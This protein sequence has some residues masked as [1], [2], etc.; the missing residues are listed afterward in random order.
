MVDVAIFDEDKKKNNEDRIGLNGGEKN[1]QHRGRKKERQ[2]DVSGV[3]F[4]HDLWD[5][6]NWANLWAGAQP[7]TLENRSNGEAGRQAKHWQDMRGAPQ[8]GQVWWN[9]WSCPLLSI[10]K[11]KKEMIIH[12]TKLADSYSAKFILGQQDWGWISSSFWI[13]VT[14]LWGGGGVGS[15]SG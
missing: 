4:H 11:K 6:P 3:S 13:M 15:G 14:C 8:K 9:P 2:Q 5:P 10:R 12:V 1:I 7:S